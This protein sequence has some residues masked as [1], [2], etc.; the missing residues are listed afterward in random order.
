VAEL[1]LDLADGG[2]Q[3]EADPELPRGGVV[4]V[5]PGRVYDGR[6]ERLLGAARRRVEAMR[7]LT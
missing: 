6:P 3:L 5:A 7:G 4:L 1:E 2:I